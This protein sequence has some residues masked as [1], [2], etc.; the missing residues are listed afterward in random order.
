MHFVNYLYCINLNWAGLH[1][2]EK[3]CKLTSPKTRVQEKWETKNA[4]M[5]RK[6]PREHAPASAFKR[7]SIER[8]EQYQK[9][10]VRRPTLL[11]DSKKFSLFG[12]SIFL[13]N[14]ISKEMM[15]WT[16]SWL[17]SKLTLGKLQHMY[18]ELWR[19]L[20]NQRTQTASLHTWR[21][22]GFEEA[23]CHL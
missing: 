4:G 10:F 21:G 8:Q 13:R 3:A 16:C 23:L 22:A 18:R 14:F 17:F 12:I 1:E 20:F 15:P 6:W 5:G 19:E 2:Y 9:N 7:S 11:C